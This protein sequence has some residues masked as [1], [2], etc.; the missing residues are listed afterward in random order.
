ML[1]SESDFQQCYLKQTLLIHEYKQE[2]DIF[3]EDKQKQCALQYELD[4]LKKLNILIRQEEQQYGFLNKTNYR[5]NLNLIK[6]IKTILIK[7]MKQI[8][9]DLCLLFSCSLL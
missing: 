8:K 6:D 5:G 2:L 1:F 3:N 7:R 9:I 4:T